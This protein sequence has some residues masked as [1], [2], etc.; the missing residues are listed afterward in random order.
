MAPNF[1]NFCSFLTV[2]CPDGFSVYA[3]SCYN[4]LDTSYDFTDQNSARKA[5]LALTN[6]TGHLAYVQSFE[7]LE[8]IGFRLEDSYFGYERMPVYVGLTQDGGVLSYANGTMD[9]NVTGWNSEQL[10]GRGY[11]SSDNRECVAMVWDEVRHQW[12]LRDIACHRQ[13]GYVCEITQ[14]KCH[15]TVN[16]AY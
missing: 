6:D 4:V 3:D 10:W 11:P 5:C 14:S 13:L 8:Y 7:E 1:V 16:S 9:V 2:T 15:C 12:L